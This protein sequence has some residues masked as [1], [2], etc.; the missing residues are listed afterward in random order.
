ME[1]AGAPDTAA[2]WEEESLDDSGVVDGVGAEGVGRIPR[3]VVEPNTGLPGGEAA[4]TAATEANDA[5]VTWGSG[6]I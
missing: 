1:E 6:G 3:P 4:A 2:E 5:V